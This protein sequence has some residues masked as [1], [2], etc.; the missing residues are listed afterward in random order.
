MFGF[1]QNIYLSNTVEDLNS[2]AMLN[3][4]KSSIVRWS[5]LKNG[6]PRSPSLEMNLFSAAMKPVI[7]WMSLTL[8]GGSHLGDG[9]H[10]FRIGFNAL[11]VDD[12]TE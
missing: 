10:F 12:K 9:G 4:A 1:L 7:F 5:N 8:R 6:R 11:V 3:T 2:S